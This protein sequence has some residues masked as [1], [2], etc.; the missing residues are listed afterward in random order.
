MH[1]EELLLNFFNFFLT[2]VDLIIE[3]RRALIFL[4]FFIG[5]QIAAIAIGT[6]LGIV[7]QARSTKDRKQK[8]AFRSY[9]GKKRKKDKRELK[10][11][12]RSEHKDESS[13]DVAS[14]TEDSSDDEDEKYKKKGK[15]KH[16][17][18]HAEAAAT[19]KRKR[20]EKE[21]VLEEV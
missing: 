7:W 15:A 2:Y 9:N 3:L 11:S 18:K 6:I 16:H 12:K 21:Q 4:L 17:R 19:R 14:T 13:S 5:I 10:K 20:K 1:V 8:G